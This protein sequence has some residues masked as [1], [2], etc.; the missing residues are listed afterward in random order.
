MEYL[1][2]STFSVSGVAIILMAIIEMGEIIARSF[3]GF[4]L[5][6]ADEFAG[7][8]LATIVFMGL[9]TCYR[10]K[11]M[12]R[13]EVVYGLFQKHPTVKCFIDIIFAVVMLIY[14]GIITYYTV[15][16]NATT[17]KFRQV[18]TSF[19][20]IP[21][22]IPQLFMSVGYICFFLYVL[23]DIYKLTSQKGEGR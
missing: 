8:F 23:L 22:G 7:Y 5:M 19:L 21:T 1:C 10:Q 6:I 2:V 4:S 15:R 18:S 16:L 11:A 3:F 17:F 12:V 20:R 14:V 13:V 9:T